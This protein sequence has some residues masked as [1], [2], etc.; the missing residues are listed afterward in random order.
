[1]RF[2]RARRRLRLLR[3]R[4][5]KGAEAVVKGIRR[6]ANRAAIGRLEIRR[7]AVEELTFETVALPQCQLALSGGWFSVALWTMRCCRRGHDGPLI[8]P[9][10]LRVRNVVL[11][12]PKGLSRIF[13]GA[14]QKGARAGAAAS[15]QA[16]NLRLRGM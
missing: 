6:A 15:R 10:K 4:P 16:P 7:N 11:G 8:C 12:R 14:R 13:P 1:M 3:Q 2:R 5:E 9:Q